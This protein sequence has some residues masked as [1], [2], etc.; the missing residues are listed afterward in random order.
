MI[1]KFNKCLN[2]DNQFTLISFNMNNKLDGITA[3]QFEDI[4]IY[5]TNENYYYYIKDIIDVGD[6]EKFKIK[7]KKGDIVSLTSVDNSYIV[8]PSKK[9]F[10]YAFN[11][12]YQK[13][14][15]YEYEEVLLE[16]KPYEVRYVKDKEEKV[17]DGVVYTLAQLVTYIST[18]I[19]AY[20]YRAVSHRKR[21]TNNDAIIDRVIMKYYSSGKNEVDRKYELN[22]KRIYKNKATGQWITDNKINISKSNRYLH[23][24]HLLSMFAYMILS[25]S[26][27]DRK[28]NNDPLYSFT[29]KFDTIDEVYQYLELHQDIVNQFFIESDT[30]FNDPNSMFTAYAPHINGVYMFYMIDDIKIYLYRSKDESNFNQKLLK[31]TYVSTKFKHKI[32]GIKNIYTI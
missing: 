10:S 12:D 1:I 6:C 20:N 29:E 7:V 26:L 23:D 15:K 14:L 11:L 32:K 3:D 9:A 8:F 22:V 24:Y 19:K 30:L 31:Q 25:K 28:I 16:G 17:N 2:D 4:N 18:L 5:E 27:Y 21:N 13:V